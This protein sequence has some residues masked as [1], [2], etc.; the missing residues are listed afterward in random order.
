MFAGELLLVA[1]IF[2]SIYYVGTRDKPIPKEVPQTGV[3]LQQKLHKYRSS[4]VNKT[5]MEDIQAE[6]AR[7]GVAIIPFFDGQKPDPEV[8][9]ELE[10]LLEQTPYV[11]RDLQ[12][13]GEDRLVSKSTYSV[14]LRKREDESDA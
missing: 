8:A 4:G 13:P 3:R 14:W 1:L 6:L 11:P 9:A 7:R 12:T 2:Y 10:M 5:Q